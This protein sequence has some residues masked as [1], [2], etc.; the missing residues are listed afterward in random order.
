[1]RIL[2]IG[3]MGTIGRR[4]LLQRLAM[5]DEVT[6]MSRD[7]RRTRRLL[8]ALGHTGIPI[9][10]G[11]PAIPG[12]WQDAVDGQDAVLMVAGAGI[13]DRR[14]SRRYLRQ[15]HQ[16]RIDGT[17]QVVRA[18]DRA[19]KRPEVFMT[20]SATGYYG[21]R[22]RV[23]TD[24]FAPAGDDALA[25]LCVDWENQAIRAEPLCRVI[26]MRFGMVLDA[27][28][29]ALAKMLPIFRKG[30]GGRLG[31]GRQYISWVAWQDVVEIVNHLL[32]S[33]DAAGAYNIVSPNAVTN[34]EFTKALAA[35]LHRPAFMAM[36]SPM[37]RVALGGIASVLL[38]GQRAW[39]S[40]LMDSG[41]EFRF[42]VLES[43]LASVLNLQQA[44]RRTSPL[45]IREVLPPAA[46]RIIVVDI[47]AF[48]PDDPGTRA[49]L[50]RLGASGAQLVLATRR[51]IDEIRW[52]MHD[53]ELD[54]PVIVSDGA[55]V[56]GRGGEHVVASRTITV[57]LLH[58][59]L[60]AARG[61][62]EPLVVELETID[63]ARH[64]LNL[65][66]RSMV[67]HVD[68]TPVFRIRVAGEEAPRVQFEA[69]V[70]ERFWKQRRVAIH[71][72]EEGVLEILHPHADR[73][74]AVQEV[75]R[76]LGTGREGVLAIVQSDRSAGL[77][78]WSGFSVALS[79]ASVTIQGLADATTASGGVDG[80]IEAH[81]QWVRHPQPT[82]PGNP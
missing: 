49:A 46:P 33:D 72:S 13:A 77:A 35:V 47:D 16:S 67:E 57:E 43:A 61:I 70:R 60:V 24:E 38:T 78:D 17:Y 48:R 59:I 27:S 50:R 15:V 68:G 26:R 7:R 76:R 63:G 62:G 25:R 81:E 2:I 54:C 82:L 37:L 21:D 42:P 55:A 31:S 1:M 73:G 58:E 65:D 79:D 11:D 34:L 30:L 10:E 19:E 74:I 51:G 45:K 6:V 69:L 22:G 71:I 8:V 3:A 4:I 23:L 20:A 28:G 14:W 40:R 80:L 41:Y 53:S 12:P 36:P 56:I 9:V 32:E 52:F 18:I 29:G 66:G 5:G 44:E 39:P 64:R 75:A